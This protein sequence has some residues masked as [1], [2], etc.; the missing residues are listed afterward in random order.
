M[1]PRIRPDTAEWIG[2]VGE[3]VQG[4]GRRGG[5]GLEKVCPG[6]SSVIG[7]RCAAVLAPVRRQGCIKSSA[8]GIGMGRPPP[9]Q[10]T[11]SALPK[12][13]VPPLPHT[14]PT[15]VPRID[16]SPAGSALPW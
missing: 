7:S 8:E 3:G 4:G 12:I 11:T 5:G 16:L 14:T 13:T 1:E 6:L 10:K 2:D 9:P 15:A